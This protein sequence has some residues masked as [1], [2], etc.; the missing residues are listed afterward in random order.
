MEVIHSFAELATILLAFGG[1]M[2]WVTK[3]IKSG[4]KE[5]MEIHRKDLKGIKKA[6]KNRVSIEDCARLRSQCLCNQPQKKEKGTMKIFAAVSMLLILTG[7]GHNVL[8]Y[9]AGKYLNLGVDPNTQKAG[10]QYVDGEQITVVEKDN[11]KLTVEM[12]DSLD[13]DGKQTSKVAKIIYEIGEQ[14]TGS[15]V[16]LTSETNRK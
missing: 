1:G 8:T 4:Q 14:I 3:S 10:I 11:T 2:I 7:C 16:A 15:D 13:A 12:R 9:S 6:L 5:Q